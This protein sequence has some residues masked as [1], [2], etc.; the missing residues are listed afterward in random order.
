MT[1][2]KVSQ[3]FSTVDHLDVTKITPNNAYN[4]MK[5]KFTRVE[6]DLSSFPAF[7]LP[8]DEIHR[9]QRPPLYIYSV[10]ACKVLI[11]RYPVVNCDLIG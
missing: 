9:Q 7:S 5:I 4:F 3:L 6:S 10:T 1:K 2:R 11:Y 8:V